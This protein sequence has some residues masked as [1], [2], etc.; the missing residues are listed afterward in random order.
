MGVY[1]DQTGITIR[2]SQVPFVPG[3][4]PPKVE[5]QYMNPIRFRINYR[6]VPAFGIF[7]LLCIGISLVLMEIDEAKYS[8]VF[9]VLLA[10][11]GV[12]SVAL[13]VSVPKTRGW[14]ISAELK[15]YD[16]TKG[17]IPEGIEFTLEQEGMKLVFR[18]DGL[19]LDGRFY[20]YNQV[21]PKFVTS[22]R[23]N[24]IWLAVQFGTDPIHSVF[25]PLSPEVIAL[26]DRFS[27]PIGNREQ[28][29]FL[30][31]HKELCFDQIYKTGT[32]HVPE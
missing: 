24:R 12:A 8:G 13:M 21:A 29:D 25:L 6:V 20:W 27:I 17:T 22:N 23:F 16:L 30:L 18:Q 2:D 15:R 32:I 19:E 28:Y 31:G 7:C 10:L 1:D 3:M 9:I 11:V 4:L 14:E 26:V 5:K